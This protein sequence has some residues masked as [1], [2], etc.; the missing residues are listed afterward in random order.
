MQMPGNQ[1]AH[2]SFVC[3][4]AQAIPDDIVVELRPARPLCVYHIGWLSGQ[5]EL[6]AHLS[7]APGIFGG[8]TNVREN[9]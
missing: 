9:G 5:P 6:L 1:A 4:M 3:A 8:Q 7:G 2:K